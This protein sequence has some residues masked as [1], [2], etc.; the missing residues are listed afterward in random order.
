MTTATVEAVP[1]KSLLDVW[2]ITVGHGFTHWYP[3]TFYLLLP[4]IGSE[5][6]LSYAQIGSILTAQYIAGAISNIPGGILV[7]SVSRKGM[8][9]AISLAWVGIPYLL[10]GFADAY[11]MLLACSALIGI[12]NNLWHPTAIP[13]LGNLYPLRR[14]L[15]M[16][17]HGMAANVGDAVAP[18][19]AGLLLTVL[20]WR[21]V[22]AVN[23]LPGVVMAILL[24]MY[25][26][27]PQPGEE[28]AAGHSAVASAAVVLRGFGS[29]LRNRT[30]TMLSIG[31]AFRSITQMSLLTFLPVYLARELGYSAVWVGACLFILQACGFAAAPIAGHLSDKIGRR[32]V[33]MSSLAMTAVVLLFMAL[34]GRSVAFVV[35]VSIL[36]FFLFAIRAVLQAWLLDATPRG[37]GG[38]SIGFMFGMQAIGGAIGP[39]IAGVVADQYGLSAMFYFLAATIV[40]ANLFMLLTPMPSEGRGTG[41]PKPATS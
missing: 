34:A 9:M 5:M 12:G 4:L 6:G 32:Q 28:R 27:R 24:V 22:M 16:S 11:W 7:D 15:V 33:V 26:G 2:L 41:N 8:L 39:F 40:V 25:F 19:V 21:G 36:G 13:L 35:F 14:G 31:S 30:V 10:M 38:T 20:S 1:R 29:L 23:V 17:F 18:L 3:A 37:M